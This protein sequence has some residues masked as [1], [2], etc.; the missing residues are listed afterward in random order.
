MSKAILMQ[1]NE[2]SFLVETDNSVEVPSNLEIKSL[3]PTDKEAGDFEEVVDLDGVIRQFSEIKQLI[4]TCCNSLYEVVNNIPKP[5]KVAIEFGI[6]L[7]G[8][9]GIPML[10][11]ASG[12]A[13]FKVNIE[14][15]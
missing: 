4:V 2:D 15:K 12:E 10:T 3:R 9:T 8:E 6:K 13:N 5:E 11:K 7:V 1:I 14:W